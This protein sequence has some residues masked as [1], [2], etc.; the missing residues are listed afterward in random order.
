MLRCTLATMLL[1]TGLAAASPHIQPFEGN[2][3]YWQYKGAPVL[4][5]GGSKDDSLYQIP[6]LEEHLDEIA[7]AGGNYVRNTMSPRQ[8]HGFEVYPHARREDGLYDLDAW[9]P[10]YWRRFRSLLDGCLERDI[11]VQIEVWDRF[12]YS[13]EQWEESPWRPANNVNY[14]V[15]ESGLADA[16]PANAWQD[17]QPFFHTIPGMPLYDPKLDLVR[18]HQE[19]L[20]ARMLRISLRYPNVLY[21]MSNETS[22]PVAWGMHWMRF[23]TDKAREQDVPAYVTDMFDDGHSPSESGKLRHAFDRPEE[24]RFIDISQVNSRTFGE[25]HWRRFTWVADQVADLPRPLNHVK[26]YSDG[27]TGWGSGTPKDGVERFWRNLI[28]GAA[29][30]R[31]HRPGAG[32]GLNDIAKACIRAARLTEERV[33]FW[34]VTRHQE[35]LSDR[36][37][38][39]AYLAAHPGEAYVLYFT[40]GDSVGLDLT[41]APGAFTLAWISVASGEADPETKAIEGGSVIT[42]EAPGP[43]GRVAVI[44]QGNEG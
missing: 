37:E 32:I 43:G 21:C 38:N 19:R 24:Y 27:Q 4:L 16:Y 18:A 15:E 2:P 13:Q 39:E 23:I 36:E 31:F 33:K 26:I 25:E 44:T 40:D 5:L 17:R 22:T 29:A 1:A 7:A 3:A 30:C 34:E 41:G 20:V 10:E 11:I 12:D 35:L 9:N 14:T 8:D 28:G 42:L 6:D